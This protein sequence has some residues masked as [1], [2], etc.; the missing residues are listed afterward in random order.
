MNKLTAS[1][2]SLA[3]IILSIKFTLNF[4][5]LYY[6]D[7]KYLHIKEN[8][9]LTEDEIKS[10]YD[11]LIYYMN[12]NKNIQFELPLLQSSKEGIIHF[13]EVKNIFKKLDLMLFCSFP[14]ILYGAYN[15]LKKKNFSFLKTSSIFTVLF[16]LAV[17][18]PFAVNFDM[19]F[20]IFH[21]IFF[22][23]NYWIF[24]PY[25]DPII[26]LLPA[27]FFFHC[28]MLIIFLMLIF[29]V[30][31]GISYRKLKKIWHNSISSV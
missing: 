5:P 3:V 28:L 29:S 16:G 15:G 7:I 27:E 18:I 8:T 20:E 23:N 17:T 26:N 21:K 1:A 30:M 22:K 31:L 12:T 2:I 4:K 25:K 10:A 13:K 11:Y 14:I 6:F 9:D 19:S 24:D